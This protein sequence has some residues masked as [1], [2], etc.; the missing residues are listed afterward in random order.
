MVLVRAIDLL[1][2][3]LIRWIH[4]P[5]KPILQPKRLIFIFYALKLLLATAQRTGC[6]DE[7]RFGFG[8][9]P[10]GQHTRDFTNFL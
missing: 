3:R 10:I 5:V 8:D 9:E 4:V 7:M 2:L 1:V 6:M